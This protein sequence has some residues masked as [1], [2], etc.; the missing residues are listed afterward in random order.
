MHIDLSIR[1]NLD[2]LGSVLPVADVATLDANR[3]EDGPEGV[4]LDGSIG[5]TDDHQSPARSEIVDRL[6]ICGRVSSDDKRGVR[7]QSLSRILDGLDEVLGLFK[8]N[9]GIGTELGHELL[10][11][12][13]GI[14]GEHFETEGFGVLHCEMAETSART[15][16]GDPVVDNGVSPLE[17]SVGSD[18]GAEDGRSSSRV[19]RVRDGRDV[20]DERDDILRKGTI[21]SVARQLGLG[22]I[23]ISRVSHLSQRTHFVAPSAELAVETAICQPF[24]PDSVSDLDRRTNGVFSNRD[25]LAQPLV[26]TNERVLRWN[27][28]ITNLGVQVGVTHARVGDLDQAFPRLEFRGLADGVVL[29]DREVS[30]GGFDHTGGLGLW[31]G[32]DKSGGLRGVEYRSLGL[33]G[34]YMRWAS[35]EVSHSRKYKSP[36]S[37]SYPAVRPGYPASPYD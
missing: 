14:N 3:L 10:L 2:R 22:A 11:G 12:G 27:R 26:S 1:G 7:A 4:G 33:C 34:T 21:Y 15:G 9:P 28:P 23:C 6:G 35:A 32:H 8:V 31:D 37:R 18:T 25:D 16:D 24:D 20:S 5:H 19:E 13:A 36:G 30:P 29:V 17:R